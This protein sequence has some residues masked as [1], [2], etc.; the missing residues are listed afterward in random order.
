V[1]GAHYDHLGF[2][3]PGSGSRQPD[4][5]AIH[6]GADDNASGV[7]AMIELAEKLSLSG[8]PLPCSFLF[9]A[10]GAEEEGLLGSKYFMEHSLIP[11]SNI[12]LMINLDMIGRLQSRSL[13][14]GGTGTALETDSILTVLQLSDS[15]NITRSPEGSG[16][17]DHAS[18]YAKDI[19]VLFFTSGPHSDYHTPYDRPDR[20]DLNGMIRISDFVYDLLVDFGRMEVPLTFRESGPKVRPAGKYGRMKVTL[21]IMP[22]FMDSDDHEGMRVDMVTPGR[23]AALGGMKKGD[24]IIAIEGKPIENVYDYM[25]RLSKVEPGH[26]IV[27]TVLRNEEKLDLL[28]QL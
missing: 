9:I 14:I 3:G 7:S 18:F 17:S 13:Q 16:P 24:Y 20:I 10:F 12:R 23:P 27:V 19:P 15:V 26:Q 25:F 1:L 8:P 21:G 6:Y 5:V 4:T 2:G 28:I 22:D 11:V